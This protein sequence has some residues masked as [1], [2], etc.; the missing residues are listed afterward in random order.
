MKNEDQAVFLHMFIGVFRRSCFG[1]AEYS[2]GC[3]GRRFGQFRS[4]G[5][6]GNGCSA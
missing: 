3:S 6:T 2:Q 5:K 4:Y 1:R